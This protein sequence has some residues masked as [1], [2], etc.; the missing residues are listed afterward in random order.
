MLTIPRGAALAASVLLLAGARANAQV[1]RLDV[2]VVESPA[3]GGERFGTV[4][5][6]ERLRGI[7]YGEVDPSDPR[8]QDIVNLEHAPH[9]ARGMVE[10]STTVEIYRPVYMS[11]WNRAIYHTVPNRGGATGDEPSLRAMGFAF[12][13]VGWQGDIRSTDRNVVP[14]LPVAR[15]SDGSPMVGRALEEFIFGDQE[16]VSR[17]PLTYPTASRDPAKATLTVRALQNSRRSTPADLRWSWVSDTEISIQRPA[18][19]DGGAIYE[20]VYEAKDPVV[21]GIGFA[22]MRDVISFLRYER[23]DAEGNFNPLDEP[24]TTALSL[25]I[26]QSGRALRDFLYL[27]FNEDTRGRIVFDG[28]HV[29]IAGSRKTFTNYAFSQPGRWQKQHEDHVYPGDQ[30]PF[31]YTMLRDPIGGGA[32]GILVRCSATDTCPRIVHTD[33]EAE[34]WQARSSLVVTDPTGNDIALPDNVRAY[35]VAGVQHGGGGGVHTMPRAGF[36]QNPNNPMPLRDIRTALSVALYEWVAKEHAPPASRFPTVG[37]GGLVAP[38]A[39][40]FPSIPGVTYSGSVNQLHL[41][42]YSTMPPKEGPA[43]TVLV[44]RVDADGNMLAGVRHPN[45]V[46][47]IGTYTG[48]NLRAEGFGEGDQCAGAGSFIPFAET[49]AERMAK[50]DQR[51][52]LEERYAD[53]AAYVR[54]VRQAAD[55]LVR[56]RLLLRADA[57]EIVAEAEASSI[58]R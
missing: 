13:R 23:H 20:F 18:G 15:N 2:D 40:G 44:G 41:M 14:F 32:D 28:M 46:A 47:P 52:S 39:T 34:I 54:A 17:A 21:M 3:L 38:A 35:L 48:W 36:C 42:D 12:V 26:S 27:G 19:F 4:G 10:Y 56:D 43:Y 53:H 22:A 9:N 11:R 29:D 33:G 50:G 8:N 51:L 7:A 25:G 30:F 58:R 49:R 16:R 31:T 24:A 55:A 5:Q 1:T 57:D 6:Y 37:N 45:L